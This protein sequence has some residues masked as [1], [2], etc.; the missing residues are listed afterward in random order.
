[1]HKFRIPAVWTLVIIFV[2]VLFI[3]SRTSMYDNNNNSYCKKYM[4]EDGTMM[5]Y[6]ECNSDPLCTVI[7]QAGSPYSCGSKSEN[8]IN[9]ETSTLTNESPNLYPRAVYSSMLT[10]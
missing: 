7:K 5:S 3:S 4:S 6:T 1:M 8:S 9:Q 10:M 2:L